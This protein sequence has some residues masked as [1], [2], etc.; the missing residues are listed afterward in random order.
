LMRSSIFVVCTLPIS[1]PNP[2]ARRQVCQLHPAACKNYITRDEE[3][4]GALNVPAVYSLSSY[5]RASRRA[6]LR[7]DVHLARPLIEKV[8]SLLGVMSRYP[9]WGS[10][11]GN[12]FE[13]RAG[14]ETPSPPPGGAATRNRP[15]RDCPPL[16]PRHVLPGGKRATIRRERPC[17]HALSD[18]MDKAAPGNPAPRGSAELTPGPW[19]R[20]IVRNQDASSSS[21][22]D[23]GA[24]MFF[25]TS[26]TPVVIGQRM[27]SEETQLLTR[28]ASNEARVG[29]S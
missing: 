18:E 25:P 27:G 10:A 19:R 8:L 12:G 7:A 22:L 3:G 20:P 5:V 24:R 15:R 21:M 9:G 17:R 1:R 26:G 2:V 23:P 11:G 16:P 29:H 28:S 4:I 13:G 6:R 14:Y